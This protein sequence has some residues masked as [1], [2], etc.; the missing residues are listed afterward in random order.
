[1]SSKIMDG[2]KLSEKINKKIKKEVETFSIPPK[3]AAIQVGNIEESNIYLKHKKIKANE[4]GINFILLKFDDKISEKELINEISKLNND[5]SI[6]GIMVQLPLPKHINENSISKSILDSKDID[7]F[8]PKNKGLLDISEAILIPPTALGVVALID[9]YKIKIK[10]KKIVVIGSGEIA[11]KPIFKLLLNRGATITM[12]N[13][14]TLNLSEFTKQAD[15]IISAV[16]SHKLVNAKNTKSNSVIIN[17]GIT[18]EDNDII[19]GDVDFENLRKTSSYITPIIG[20]TGPL[21]V[22][23]LLKNT[24]IA[25]KN[26][27]KN[28]NE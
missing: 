22:S 3:L 15:I 11:G 2:T 18:R 24:V 21:T 13:K 19:K 9:E 10:G 16:G 5:E 1:M 17:V 4:L 26:R 25:K 20:G 14:N 27:E 12:C 23:Y 7:G 6:D 8:N 28:K